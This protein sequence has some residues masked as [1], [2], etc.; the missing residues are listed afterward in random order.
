MFKL[1]PLIIGSPIIVF[2]EARSPWEAGYSW[3]IGSFHLHTRLLAFAFAHG[4]IKPSSQ[5]APVNFPYLHAGWARS[6]MIKIKAL[7]NFMKQAL[8]DNAKA[9]QALNE[10]RIQMRKAVIQNRMALDVLTAA[11]GGTRAIIKIECCSIYP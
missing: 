9:I 11:Q 10:E 3:Y 2:W 4:N 6:V 1:N 7:T 8:L 5:Q